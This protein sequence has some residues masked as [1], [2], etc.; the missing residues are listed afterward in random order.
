VLLADLR[1]RNAGVSLPSRLGKVTPHTIASRPEFD[2]ELARVA[3]RGWAVAN[4][5]I[6]VGFVAVAAPVRDSEGHAIAAL[7]VQGPKSRFTAKKIAQSAAELQAA[8]ARVEE[9]LGSVDP[10]RE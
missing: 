10:G 4:E 9:R 7:S 6:E 2:R 3:R 1:S 5:E 8:A